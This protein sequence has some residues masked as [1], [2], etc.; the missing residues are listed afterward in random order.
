V[1]ATG[2]RELTLEELV[3]RES[4]IRR[5]LW[6]ARFDNFTNQLDNTGK[7]KGLRRDL[8]RVKTVLNERRRAKAKG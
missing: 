8:A 7:L 4:T 2:L 3:E 5:D 6:K 1:K